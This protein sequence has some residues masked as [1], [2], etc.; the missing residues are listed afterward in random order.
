[1]N[2]EKK[3]AYSLMFPRNGS[4][5]HSM[6][7]NCGHETVHS[8]GYNWNG[9]SR[10]SHEL[11]IWQYTLAG[12][13]ALDFGGRTIALV[14]GTGFLLVVPE[15]HRYYLPENS[16]GWEFLFASFN[17]S[18]VLRIAGECRRRTGPV[19]SYD[20][21]GEVVRMAWQLLEDCRENRLNNVYAAS[22]AAYSFMMGL[23]D[24]AEHE[25]A[26][27]NEMLVSQVHDYCLHNISRQISVE[28]VAAF[29]GLSRWHLSR[30]F[31]QA[32]GKPLHDF[33]V[34]LKMRMA[35]RRLQSS[36]DSVKE[37]SVFCGFDDPSYF[38]KV[39]KRIYGTTPGEFRSCSTLER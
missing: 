1:M 39:F 31:Q 5:L 33:I 34:E 2:G 22:R 10:G 18:E 36:R 17:G 38:C 15:H 11:L 26:D 35:V 32:Y 8:T 24:A 16:S 7:V 19:A 29:A 9:M 21:E 4:R 27:S 30:R 3:E 14:P 25:Q 20:P 23:L 37:I 12:Q 28:D 6:L 13:G